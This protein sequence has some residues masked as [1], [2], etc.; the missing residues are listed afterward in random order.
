MARTTPN[1][2]R[3]RLLELAPELR[4]NIF[5]FVFE[6]SAPK[7]I[8]IREWKQHAP[9]SAITATNHQLHA[10][11][12]ARA[13]TAARAFWPAHDFS[14]TVERGLLDSRIG[15]GYRNHI[16]TLC[17]ELSPVAKLTRFSVVIKG[18]PDVKRLYERREVRGAGS[19]VFLTE[20]REY[21]AVKGAE[22]YGGRGLLAADGQSLVLRHLV[23]ETLYHFYLIEDKPRYMRKGGGA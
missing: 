23:E 17:A 16:Y 9:H 11:T 20:T 8:D 18:G 12:L 4:N 5:D 2:Q 22:R 7:C 21:K 13:E 1:A 14:V 10:E 3:C 6:D 19:D 15:N